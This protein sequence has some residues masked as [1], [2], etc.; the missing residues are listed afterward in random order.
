MVMRRLGELMLRRGRLMLLSVAVA[1]ATAVAAHPGEAGTLRTGLARGQL[2]RVVPYVGIPSVG[3]GIGV[4]QAE[5]SGGSAHASAGVADFGMMSM[6]LDAVAGK[7]PVPLPSLPSPITADDR[8]HPDVE[9]DPIAPPSSTPAPPTPPAPPAPPPATSP[10]QAPAAVSGLAAAVPVAALQPADTTTTSAPPAVA[11]PAAPAAPAAPALAWEEAHASKAPA[12]RARVR[13][14]EVGVPG[15]LTFT[16]G[17]SKAT[18]DRDVTTSTVTLGRLVLGGAG[19]A[20]EV[21]LSNLVWTASQAMGK[22]GAASFTIG[23]ITV[24]GQAL[25]VPPGAAPADALNAVNDALAAVGL[26]LEIPVSTGDAAGAAVSSLVIQV[27]NPEAVA[28]LVGQAAE[29]VVPVLNQIL[30]TLLAAAPDASAS[31]LVVNALLATGTT[32]GGGR[33]ELGGASA[34]IGNVEVADLVPPLPPPVGTVDLPAGFTPPFAADAAPA[35]AL[36]TGSAYGNGYGSASFESSMPVAAPIAPSGA[37]RTPL[38]PAAPGGSTLAARPVGTTAPGGAPAPLVL[39]A[40]LLAIAVLA[41]GD[42]LR[43]RRFQPNA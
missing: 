27:R 25:P 43:L 4:A 13:G 20:P 15:V 5:V 14:P 10:E 28:H 18:A 3:A 17:E 26:R 16:G 7:S 23:A 34:R 35:P 36:S 38:P 11:P 32:R 33:L 39:G 40:A 30:D 8:D 24:A 41:V 6:I 29:P 2:A 42:K 31:R 19:G 37:A 12:S 1:A 21:V 22:P 9:R